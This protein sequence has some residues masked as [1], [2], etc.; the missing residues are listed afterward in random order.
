[1]VEAETVLHPEAAAVRIPTQN[2][3]VNLVHAED[4]SPEKK[5]GQQEEEQLAMKDLG[6]EDGHGKW[7]WLLMKKTDIFMNWIDKND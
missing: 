2:R 6:M 1:M 3:A 7:F 4:H 5:S